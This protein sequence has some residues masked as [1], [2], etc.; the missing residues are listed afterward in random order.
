MGYIHHSSPLYPSYLMDIS[1]GLIDI[2]AVRGGFISKSEGF[3]HLHMW[4]YPPKFV[5]ISPCPAGY[6]PHYR[7]LYPKPFGLSVL[8]IR[9]LGRSYK[10]SPF[11]TGF[12][13]EDF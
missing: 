6:I 12:K 5:V 2:S 7:W 11:L 9:F 8:K 4:F 3:I 13:M 1:T 10:K